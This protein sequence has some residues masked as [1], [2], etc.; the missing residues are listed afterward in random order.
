[1]G[2]EPTETVPTCRCCAFVGGVRCDVRCNP[3]S[4]AARKGRPSLRSF[5]PVSPWAWSYRLPVKCAPLSI[6]GGHSSV[7]NPSLLRSWR[8]DVGHFHIV[9]PWVLGWRCVQSYPLR[10]YS[11]DNQASPWLA[12]RCS[13]FSY[14]GPLR[15]GVLPGLTSYSIVGYPAWWQFMQGACSCCSLCSSLTHAY[16]ICPRKVG[17]DFQAKRAAGRDLTDTATPTGLRPGTW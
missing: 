11:W 7:V 9:D 17:G 8:Y 4:P 16:F 3:C 5:S 14:H 2:V 1:M 13:G 6:G 10:A 12:L 15:R